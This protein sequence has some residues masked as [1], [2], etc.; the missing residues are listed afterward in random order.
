[1]TKLAASIA[2]KAVEMATISE[3]QSVSLSTGNGYDL[4]VSEGFHFDW[5][6][7]VWL[8]I[9]VLLQISNIVK[10]KLPVSGFTP[11]IDMPFL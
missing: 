3:A 6:R 9:G 4:L 7:L 2:S 5:E 8:V 1:M 11:C 10:A